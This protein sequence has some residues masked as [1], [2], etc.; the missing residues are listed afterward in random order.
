MP[1]LDLKNRRINLE[2]LKLT[3][4]NKTIAEL[5]NKIN[6]FKKI[7]EVNNSYFQ[8]ERKEYIDRIK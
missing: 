6:E 7:L 8:I 4:I 5:I 1:V 3:T 2:I